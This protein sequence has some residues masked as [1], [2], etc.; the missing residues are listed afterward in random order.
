MLLKRGNIDDNQFCEDGMFWLLIVFLR[1]EIEMWKWKLFVFII[2][3]GECMHIV[4]ANTLNQK[5]NMLKNMFVHQM[6][7]AC[8]EHVNVNIQ[9]L[10]FTI[11][12]F[13]VEF[14]M[15]HELTFFQLIT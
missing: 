10:M 4:N 6:T 12:T 13:I 2:N 5:Q 1:Y 7:H 11:E 3:K 8:L 15:K 14:A 9:L